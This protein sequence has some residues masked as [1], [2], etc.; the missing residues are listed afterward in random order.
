MK[1]NQIIK[2]IE[3]IKLIN[4]CIDSIQETSKYIVYQKILVLKK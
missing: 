3:Q 2:N 4:N 1:Y